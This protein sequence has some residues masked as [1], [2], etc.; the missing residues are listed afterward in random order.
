MPISS[1][2]ALVWYVQYS[3]RKRMKEREDDEG[4]GRKSFLFDVLLDV[5]QVLYQQTR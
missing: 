4:N 2:V 3:Q 5:A 1:S